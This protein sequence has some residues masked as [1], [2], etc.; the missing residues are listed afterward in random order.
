M[1]DRFIIESN[2][3]GNKDISLYGIFDGHGG[4]NTSQYLVDNFKKYLCRCFQ[5]P[6]HPRKAIVEICNE[7]DS[8][9]LKIAE[10]QNDSIFCQIIINFHRFRKLCKFSVMYR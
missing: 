5:F 10:S 7:I 3:K 1:E 4:S 8:D 6:L 2:L 9:I